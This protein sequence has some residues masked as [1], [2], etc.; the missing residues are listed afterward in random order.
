MIISWIQLAWIAVQQ[1]LYKIN[2]MDAVIFYAQAIFAVVLLLARITIVSEMSKNE[3]NKALVAVNL[4]ILVFYI[5]M[6]EQYTV[7]ETSPS[8][9]A[10]ILCTN[11]PHSRAFRIL[12][13]GNTNS[14]YAILSTSISMAFVF[15]QALLAVAG[16]INFM[17]Q[18]LFLFLHFIDVFV[19]NDKVFVFI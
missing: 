16:N 3:A 4:G 10:N 9:P 5:H 2:N 11:N 8:N 13:L 17:T 6:L 15:V 19:C 7:F 14:Q 18:V 1:T 12:Y